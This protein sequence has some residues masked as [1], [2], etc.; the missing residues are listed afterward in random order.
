MN[1]LNVEQLFYT[2]GDIVTIRHNVPNKFVGWIVE[3]VNRNVKNTEGSYD[4]LFVGMKVRWFNN[5]GDLQE[6]VISTKDLML[7]ED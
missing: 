7:V 5:N 2:P 3:K 4:N 1:N 6:A